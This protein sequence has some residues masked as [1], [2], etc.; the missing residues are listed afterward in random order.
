MQKTNTLH[1][2]C[3]TYRWLSHIPDEKLKARTNLTCSKQV[4]KKHFF[5]IIR[6]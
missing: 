5:M 2:A 4:L 6:K 1:S 3:I